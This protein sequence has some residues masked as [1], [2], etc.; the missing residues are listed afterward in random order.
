LKHAAIYAL[1]ESGAK[2]S[3]PAKHPI[4]TRVS[5]MHKA[6]KKGA[7]A[8]PMP[9]IQLADEIAVAP[10]VAAKQESRL[11]ELSALLPEGDATRGEA[12]FHNAS[13]SL[14]L[15]CHVMGEEGVEFG[16]DL[17]KIGAIRSQRD[18]LEAIVY[19]SAMIARYFEMV[20]VKKKK[21]GDTAGLIRRDTTDHLV[22]AAAPGIEQPV[23]IRDI[24]SAQ[25]SPVSLM[26][27]VFDAMLQPNEIADLVAYL[28]QT[29]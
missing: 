13:K 8:H 29:K 7:P 5:Q 15:T 1:Y 9:E 2:E 12:I 18:L 20:M 17:T 19:P 6:V 24:E 27:E 11:N 22:L 26:P 21:G 4:S 10:E 23:P 14:C 16:P 3:L 28:S 25:Y